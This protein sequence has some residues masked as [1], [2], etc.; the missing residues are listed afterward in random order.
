MGDLLAT[1]HCESCDDMIAKATRSGLENSDEERTWATIED[2]SRSIRLFFATMAIV[3]G[4]DIV[5]IK[6]MQKLFRPVL[7][8]LSNINDYMEEDKHIGKKKIYRFALSKWYMDD[9]KTTWNALF[10]NASMETEEEFKLAPVRR[11]VVVVDA[12]ILERA[13]LASSGWPTSLLERIKM[14]RHVAAA[15]AM[16]MDTQHSYPGA[17]KAM[18]LPKLNA[19]QMQQMIVHLQ[20]QVKGQTPVKSVDKSGVAESQAKTKSS[21]LCY[22]SASITG[23]KTSNCKHS[24]YFVKYWSA[25]S[26]GTNWEERAALI[27]KEHENGKWKFKPQYVEWAKAYP[28]STQNK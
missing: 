1:L 18:P 8:E 22:A 16:T 6:E 20:A 11:I 23:C 19:A 24:H 9:V 21:A 10:T 7:S 4:M 14:Y 2:V 12:L 3:W 25:I 26:V 15:N 27:K 13:R 5:A 17:P 28:F